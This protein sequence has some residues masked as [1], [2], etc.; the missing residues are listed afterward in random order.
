VVEALAYYYQAAGFDSS[1]LEAVNRASVMSAGI[2]SGNIGMNVRNDIQRRK[3]W[4]KILTEAENY[5]SKHLPFEIIYD[6]ALIQGKVDYQQETVN[7]STFV[8]INA[9]KES[10]KVFDAITKG[11]EITGKRREWG[12][13]FWPV[14]SRLFSDQQ[15][16]RNTTE[17]TYA[18]ESIDLEIGLFNDR[19]SCISRTDIELNGRV[20]FARGRKMKEESY[21]YGYI[22]IDRTTGTRYSVDTTKLEFVPIST[23]RFS[24]TSSDGN[25]VIFLNINANDITD[26]MKVKIISIN[27]IDAER[28][29]SEGYIRITMG[30]I[31]PRE[32]IDVFKS[33]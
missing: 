6:T 16:S 33:F 22:I 12:F 13:G 1:L 5:F 26:N 14:S 9:L 32:W 17:F 2:S 11:L 24:P 15:Y 27:G 25:P 4:E 8:S 30:S 21:D 31:T 28:A 19:N 20:H 10:F 7:L 18:M 3:E 23:I 29:M